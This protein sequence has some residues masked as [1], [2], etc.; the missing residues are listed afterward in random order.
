MKLEDL[1]GKEVHILRVGQKRF[2]FG[3]LKG[4]ESSGIWIEGLDLITSIQKPAT[5]WPSN[6]TVFVPF[7]HIEILF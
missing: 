1:V 7:A 4:I 6:S 2:N 3:K 5:P